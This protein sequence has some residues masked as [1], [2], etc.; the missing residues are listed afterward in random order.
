MLLYG[1]TLMIAWIEE[2]IALK[3]CFSISLQPLSYE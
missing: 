2:G 3:A 1:T